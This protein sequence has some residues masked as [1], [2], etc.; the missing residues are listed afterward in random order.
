MDRYVIRLS[1][2]CA[3]LA[4]AAALLAGLPG[5]AAPALAANGVPDSGIVCTSG[6]LSGSTRSFALTTDDGYIQLP[7]GNTV[8]MWSFDNPSIATPTFQFPGPVLCANQ[9]ETVSVTLTN[10]LPEATSLI[11][12]GQENVLAN[13]AASFPQT[14]GALAP[15]AA[16]T[17]G[18]ITYSFVASEPGTYM[19]SSGSG[20]EKQVQMGLVGGIVVRPTLGAAY[21]YNRA[22]TKFNPQTEYIELL[23]EIDPYLHQAV[24]RGQFYDMNAY[25]PRYFLINGR[26]FPDTIAPNNAAWL[27][28]Q[29]YSS[30]A[31][32]HPYSAAN[33]TP[34]LMRY[35]GVGTSDY[36]FHPHGN[37]AKVIGRDGRV[38][39]GAGGQ[40][41]AYDKFSIPVGPGQNLGCDLH[42]EGCREL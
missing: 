22:D 18:T 15:E 38:L 14:S 1:S 39:A 33:S 31:H 16:A 40:D 37:S 5:A 8:Y 17:N 9:G 13:G 28:S 41:L 42:L 11:F 7:D 24:E 29:P 23:S 10:T 20:G 6:T 19:Y 26:S 27:P 25:H 35:I 21:A 12:P 30:L 36:P 32:I 4:M 2:R 34:A 3:A